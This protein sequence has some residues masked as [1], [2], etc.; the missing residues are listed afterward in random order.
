MY[1][2]TNIL[3]YWYTKY[4]SILGAIIDLLR[5]TASEAKGQELAAVSVGGGVSRS[6][7]GVAAGRDSPAIAHA[8][9]SA[10]S[11]VLYVS[12]ARGY[13]LIGTPLPL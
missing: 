6:G 11:P 10:A 8:L 5:R 4:I 13:A 1:W 9:E 2:Y 12:V 7:E 3:V